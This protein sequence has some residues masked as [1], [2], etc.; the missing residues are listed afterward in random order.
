MRKTFGDVSMEWMAE[1]PEAKNHARHQ[2]EHKLQATCVRWFRYQYPQ[3][4]HALFAVPNGG[5]RNKIEAGKLKG[6]GVLAGVADLILLQNIGTYGALCIEM[7]T[8]TGV[9]SKAQ[10]EWQMK[11]TTDGYP[12]VIIRSLDQFIETINLYL[13]GRLKI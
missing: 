7:K 8:P 5:S 2:D 3:I 13:S 6:E 4:R 12:Y 1:H 10:K 11:I 9:Q